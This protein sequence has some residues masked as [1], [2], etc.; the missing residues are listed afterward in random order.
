MP[1]TSR[2]PVTEF[3]ATIPCWL[4]RSSSR[5]L[6][7]AHDALG[8]DQ[9]WTHSE[10]RLSERGWRIIEINGRLG[11]DLI[12]Y[13]G[14]LASGIEPG[15]A[16]AAVATGRQPDLTVR[17]RRHAHIRFV[18][19]SEDCRV[20]SVALP[21]ARHLGGVEHLEARALAAPGTV[22]RLPPSGYVARIGYALA[23]GPDPGSCDRAV[24]AST[25]A[26]SYEA[27]PCWSASLS[28]QGV[29]TSR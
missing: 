18:Y 12:P 28:N 14:F 15:P 13:L 21:R 1:P 5:I 29:G 17:H 26:I 3:R 7:A 19:P 23:A 20:T 25:P 22:L 11:G 27:E 10:L 16:A 6:Q 8:L 24:R 2:R 4:T 9:A